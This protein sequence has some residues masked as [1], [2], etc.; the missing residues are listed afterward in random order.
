MIKITDD[1]L[2]GLKVASKPV[3]QTQPNAFTK[4]P[5][6]VL[7]V[8]DSVVVQKTYKVFLNRYHGCQ[9]ITASNGREAVSRLADNPD[10][11]L[12]LL[13]LNM[14]IMGGVAF[15]EVIQCQ[16]KYASIPVVI[17]TTEEMTPE[18][19]HAVRRSAKGYIVKPL[20]ANTL[21]SIISRLFGS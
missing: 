4:G 8:E 16:K 1:H 18:V 14:P 19:R 6:K 2:A 20:T 5:K 21:Y 9:V 15:M 11:E 17:V 10:V 12:I 7:I 13:D 3:F